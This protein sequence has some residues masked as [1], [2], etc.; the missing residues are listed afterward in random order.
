[1]AMKNYD[2]LKLIEQNQYSYAGS[3][4]VSGMPLPEWLKYHPQMEKEQLFCWISA[5]FA[6]LGQIHRCRGTPCYRYVNPYSLIVDEGQK[7]WFL[8][9]GADANAEQE[10][11]MQRRII[12]EYFLPPEESY[13]QQESVQLD[14]YGL[15][16]TLQYLLAQAGPE[17][18]MTKREERK[19]RRLIET[20]TDWTHSRSAQEYLQLS[21][22]IPK[23]RGTSKGKHKGK[24]TDSSKKTARILIFLALLLL[25]AAGVMIVQQ[26]KI[27]KKA[28]QEASASETAEKTPAQGKAGQDNQE[29][30]K[31]QEGAEE[32]ETQESSGNPLRDT[33]EEN[34]RMQLG[35][36]YFLECGDYEKSK[37]C[38][39][40]LAED[41]LAGHLAVLSQVLAGEDME[42]DA[43]RAV[44]ERAKEEA[45]GRGEDATAYY[46]CLLRG[47]SYLNSAKDANERLELATACL[48]QAEEERKAEIVANMAAAY[49]QLGQ[50]EEAAKMYREQKDLETDD[51]VKIGLY[52]KMARLLSQLEETEKAQE[53]LREG[54]KE[55]PQ[56]AELWMELMEGQLSNPGI[57]R[58][59][60]IQTIQEAME[61]CPQLSQE[62]AF[63]KLLKQNGLKIKGGNVCENK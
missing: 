36:L 16:K 8:D 63:Q 45:D 13:Y 58:T 49:E 44:L 21:K 14:Y 20:C 33:G 38:F 18:R 6:G 62:E 34:A 40:D 39:E 43:F 37:E 11:R 5:M 52:Q 28:R 41:A 24:R 42:E 10:K 26:Q 60:C 47:Y 31:Q 15:G 53:T 22:F 23:W 7:I 56:S 4:C 27:A 17:P 55:Y 19:C 50:Y 1:M 35:L 57:P 12:R 54:L 46:A 30:Q 48:A 59:A 2:V 32:K 51:A 3:E 61:E 9:F 29:S 25:A